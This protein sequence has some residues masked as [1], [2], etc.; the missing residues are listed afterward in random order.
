VGCRNCDGV[1]CAGVGAGAGVLKMS[2]KSMLEAIGA[3]AEDIEDIEVCAGACTGAP[4][5]KM[6]SR[7]SSEVPPGEGALPTPIA[8]TT[9]I[10]VMEVIG[11][12]S[13]NVL[14]S[15]TARLL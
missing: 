14:S 13:S 1:P 15:S 8:P 4:P 5:P 6:S 10:E 2:S 12:S 9:P 7:S 11:A 3:G